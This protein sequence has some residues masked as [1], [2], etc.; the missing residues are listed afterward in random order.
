MTKVR[1]ST[2]ISSLA[3]CLGTWTVAVADSKPAKQRTRGH[4]L[5][6][7]RAADRPLTDPVVVCPMPIGRSAPRRWGR[8]VPDADG[9]RSVRCP[10]FSCPNSSFD[11]GKIAARYWTNPA[12]TPAMTE[13]RNL[14]C[15]L[16]LL[17]QMRESA[18]VECCWEIRLAFAQGAWLTLGN[19]L[20]LLLKAFWY[21]LW[22]NFNLQF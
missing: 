11:C 14:L 12:A 19:S 7:T 3:F 1:G 9:S 20:G 17:L 4:E 13:Q 21:Q 15:D 6:E 16:L 8:H 10:F 18:V 22:D 2:G 5:E